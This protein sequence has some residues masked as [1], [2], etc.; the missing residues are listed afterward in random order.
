MK[1]KRYK[2]I[3]IEDFTKIKRGDRLHCEYNGL[4]FTQ[5]ANSDAYYNYDCDEPGWE[6][7]T[8]FG[9]FSSDSVCVEI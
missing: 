1:M 5:K 6:V 7:E 9:I 2:P 4:G 3:S 8:D